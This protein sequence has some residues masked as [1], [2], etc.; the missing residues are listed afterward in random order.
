MEWLKMTFGAEIFITNARSKAM[1]DRLL[2]IYRSN[3]KYFLPN[4]YKHISIDVEISFRYDLIECN[5]YRF[6]RYNL[7]R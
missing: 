4:S 5:Y 7:E 3:L 6:D 1:K 2:S